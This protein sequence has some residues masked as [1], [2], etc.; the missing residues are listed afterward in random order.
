MFMVFIFRNVFSGFGMRE[1]LASYNE[2]RLDQGVGVVGQ[3][4]TVC[5]FEIL[6]TI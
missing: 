1:M 2:E 3:G 5:H 6:N 4:T